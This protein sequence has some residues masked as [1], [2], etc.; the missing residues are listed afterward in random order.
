LNDLS[1]NMRSYRKSLGMTQK[2]LGEKAGIA[3]E[4]VSEIESG[5]KSPSVEVLVK[6]C[7]AL[8]CSADYLVGTPKRSLLKEEGPSLALTADILREI[9][10][11]RLTEDELMKAIKVASLYHEEKR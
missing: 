9:A 10:D 2:Q 11:R 4:F 6:L 7:G 3:Q 1:Y 8:G 5:K